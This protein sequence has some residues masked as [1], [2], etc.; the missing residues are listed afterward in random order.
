MS[1]LIPAG[2]SLLQTA[3]LCIFWDVVSVAYLPTVFRVSQEFT[4]WRLEA[5]AS[6]PPQNSQLVP[7][8]IAT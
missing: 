4:G 6:S 5:T 7:F 2:S 8:C 1:R 3:T